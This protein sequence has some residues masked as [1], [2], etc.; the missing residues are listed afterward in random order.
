MFKINTDLTLRRYLCRTR[1]LPILTV[2]PPFS[3]LVSSNYQKNS[4]RFWTGDIR[5]RSYEINGILNERSPVLSNVRI[6][7]GVSE[8]GQPNLNSFVILPRLHRQTAALK[9]FNTKTDF[10]S[11]FLTDAI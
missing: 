11:S 7:N 6:T 8:I 9:L 3:K 1:S 5:V 4:Y 10:I 2:P